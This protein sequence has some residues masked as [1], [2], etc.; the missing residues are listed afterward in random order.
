MDLGS[1]IMK[2][3]KKIWIAVGTVFSIILIV[4]LAF[5]IY[6]GIYYHSTDYA[7]SCVSSN[8]TVEVTKH[9][10]Y[11]EFNPKEETKRAMIF[12]PGAKVEYTA[13]APLCKE[14]AEGGVLCILINMP[15]RMAVLD[16][17]AAKKN[18]SKV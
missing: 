15:F 5:F 2:K 10:N 3:K 13:Y 4:F 8:E 18:I 17:D 1:E 12:Y 6:T 9:K 14:L 11:L 16:S 7:I